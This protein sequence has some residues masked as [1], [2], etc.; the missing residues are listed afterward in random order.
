MD[1]SDLDPASAS[2]ATRGPIRKKRVLALASVDRTSPDT[3]RSLLVQVYPSVRQLRIC[4]SAKSMHV[5]PLHG[6]AHP[7]PA[8][9]GPGASPAAPRGHPAEAPP[10]E[11]GCVAGRPLFS[12]LLI[13]CPGRQRDETTRLS[14]IG[15]LHR[16]SETALR[17]APFSHARYCQPLR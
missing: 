7:G 12:P 9:P 15:C 2:E 16:L 17:G 10:G 4:L 5:R 13:F 8:P 6:T 3:A 11:R 1:R 14:R